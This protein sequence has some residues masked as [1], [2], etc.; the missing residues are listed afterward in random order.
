MGRRAWGAAVSLSLALLALGCSP[1]DPGPLGA[2]CSEKEECSSALCL[3]ETR[4]D[5][6]TGWPDGYCTETCGTAESCPSGASCLQLGL[7]NLC[8]QSCAT[9][10]DCRAGYL[11]QPVAAVCL[12]DCR[13]GWDCGDE[14]VCGSEGYCVLPGLEPPVEDLDAGVADAGRPDLGP[15]S[16]GGTPDLG[17]DPGS[18]LGPPPP[19][20]RPVGAPCASSQECLTD[21]CQPQRPSP[22]GGLL[23][24]DGSCTL[25]CEAQPC[26]PGSGCIQL[27]EGARCAAPC[28]PQGVCR[29][30]Y[31]C[32]PRMLVCVPS[33][34]EGYPCPDG[35]FC[36]ARGV[37]GGGPG[38]GG[39]SGAF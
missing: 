37:C 24:R 34:A 25:P 18:D 38:P 8:L 5:E 33:C 13:R 6:P 32:H 1:A 17:G 39:G 36:N 15:P 29:L 35:G 30:G 21:F 3:P 7:D 27:V 28:G 16:D 14:F 4:Y 19:P 22:S 31:A 10:V 23:W 12:P 11:C 9:S 26:P 20:L 2:A